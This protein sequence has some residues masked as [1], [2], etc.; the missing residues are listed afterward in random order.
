MVGPQRGQ[1][2][3]RALPYPRHERDPILGKMKAP[4]LAARRFELGETEGGREPAASAR[5]TA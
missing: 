3:E 2:R 1:A 5:L 4:S